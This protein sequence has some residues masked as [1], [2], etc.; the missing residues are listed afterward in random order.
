MREDTLAGMYYKNAPTLLNQE[1]EKAFES[2][3]GPGSMPGQS[4]EEDGLQGIIVPRF[5]YEIAAP[6][7]AWGYKALQER[8]TSDVY[9]IVSQ[10][11]EDVTYVTDEPFKTP[12]GIVR[13]DQNLNRTLTKRDDVEKNDAAFDEDEHV[14]SQLPLLQFSTAKEGL[15]ILPIQISS[16]TN[17]KELSVDIKE[18]LMDQDKKASVITPTNITKYGADHTY[19]PFSQKPVKQVEELDRGFI[20]RLKQGNPRKVLEY[21][22]DHSMNTENIIGL[23]FTLI[24]TKPEEVLLEQYYGTNEFT[25]DDRNFITFASMILK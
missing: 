5:K 18:A 25:K 2:Q 4:R 3:K 16:K 14:R 24:H 8:T 6:C 7:S 9:I 20:K 19:I 12:Y 21:Y 15:K 11:N 13:V 1:L 23:L 17:L 22:E 10:S